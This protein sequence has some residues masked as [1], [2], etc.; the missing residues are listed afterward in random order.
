MPH[1]KVSYIKKRSKAQTAIKIANVMFVSIILISMTM[2][3]TMPSNAQTSSHLVQTGGQSFHDPPALH[4]NSTMIQSGGGKNGIYYYNVKIPTFTVLVNIVSCNPTFSTT[5][6]HT[7]S[8][9]YTWTL[10]AAS[11]ISCNGDSINPV[12]HI[13]L[14]NTTS[15]YSFELIV[16]YTE[17]RLT[18]STSYAINVAFPITSSG[19]ITQK[20]FIINDTSV[21]GNYIDY[22]ALSSFTPTYSSNK[23]MVSSSAV[24]SAIA[25]GLF[26]PTLVQSGSN[27]N[28]AS[29]SITCTLSSTVNA[30]DTVFTDA[31]SSTAN[32]VKSASDSASGLSTSAVNGGITG[33]LYTQASD[34]SLAGLSHTQFTTGWFY[35]NK[36]SASDT[37]TWPVSGG[38]SASNMVVC[39]D[40]NGGIY[41]VYTGGSANVAT[42]TGA[43]VAIAVGS[44]TPLA[45]QFILIKYIFVKC[46]AAIVA[47]DITQPAGFTL[48]VLA[49][50]VGSGTTGC[51]QTWYTSLAYYYDANW[52]GGASTF[53]TT[54]AFANNP[55]ITESYEYIRVMAFNI[56]EPPVST[57][58]TY[59]STSSTTTTST[60]TTTSSTT[61][62]T[63]YTNTT[64]TKTSTITSTG[65]TTT[66]QTGA[67]VNFIDAPIFPIG[68][69]M[70]I[71]W[72]ALIY[73]PKNI[74]IKLLGSLYGFLVGVETF[75]G[76]YW[77]ISN[78]TIVQILSNFDWG[79]GVIIFGIS[80]IYSYL[81]ATALLKSRGNTDKIQVE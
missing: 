7:N 20:G 24:S 81:F 22:T 51:A 67:V 8:S 63:I 30:G 2:I 34:P 71:F 11:A 3:L 33:P 42:G 31:I 1:R 17:T 68:Y 44:I 64:T 50:S 59:S 23:L 18:G 62:T 65:T 46:G 29:S 21:V 57:T 58:T 14:V 54:L 69:A 60:S 37:L 5:F 45:H 70:I 61:T 35:E 73:I 9:A 56:V 78:G 77:L 27:S 74:Y 4:V 40:V 47:G 25:S 48:A 36:T 53:S 28:S 12:V 32:N 79:L 80:I 49:T 19:S 66:T 52:A 26:D 6:T 43:S 16:K 41:Q 76:I 72:L 55:S 39:I 13:Y 15:Q 75:L 10:V 38:T